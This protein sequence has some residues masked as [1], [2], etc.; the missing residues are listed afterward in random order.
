MVRV[1]ARTGSRRPRRQR[2]DVATFVSCRQENAVEVGW[3]AGETYMAAKEVVGAAAERSHGWRDPVEAGG[4]RSAVAPAGNPDI[5]LRPS[6]AGVFR[7]GKWEAGSAGD[8]SERRW[9]RGGEPSPTGT[10][11][12]RAASVHR[13]R[14]RARPSA[15][16]RRPERDRRLLAGRRSH[17]GRARQREIRFRR[18]LPPEGCR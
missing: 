4:D 15:F 12:V 13:E 16:R 9:T 6:L 18:L 14:R 8:R 1:Q 2:R 17:P 10:G 3:E 7:R 11:P 5:P